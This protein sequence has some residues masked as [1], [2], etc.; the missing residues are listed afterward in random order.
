MENVGRLDELEL[1]N[2][3]LQLVRARL[4]RAFGAVVAWGEDWPSTDAETDL[5][6]AIRALVDIVCQVDELRME[7]RQGKR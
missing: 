6:Q 2:V 4:E 1:L 3:R 5:K 7:E